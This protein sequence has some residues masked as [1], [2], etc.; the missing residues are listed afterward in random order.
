MSN[1]LSQI[2]NKRLNL[3]Q[4]F[5]H[6]QCLLCLA[7]CDQSLCDACIRSLPW[8]PREHCPACLLPMTPARLCGTCL[9]KPPVWTDAKAALQ[10]A[11]PVDAMIQALKYQT[12][13]TLAPVLADLLFAQ[14]ASTTRP[15]CV[16]PVPIHSARLRQRGFN[17]AL[18]IGR[19]LCQKTGD[20][21]LP[22]ACTRTRETPSQTALSWKK[23]R[24]NV[25]HT[26]ACALDFSGQHVAILDDV[27]TSG[28]TLA[29]MA[30][31]IRRQGAA[32]ISIWVVA[33]VLPRPFANAAQCMIGDQRP[34]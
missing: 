16:V 9:V 19:H 7:A 21:L 15:D 25:R 8:L 1:F 30:S 26:F 11:F 5:Q 4:L 33:R 29:E 12:D 23:R 22:D 13:L 24:K 2:L 31:V 6:G 10:Y 14:I 18:E 27:M 28:A 32:R 20:K 17:Q 3:G 34:V